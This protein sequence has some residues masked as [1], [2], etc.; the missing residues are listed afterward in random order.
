MSLNQLKTYL[1]EEGRYKY[2]GIKRNCQLGVV[3]IEKTLLTKS[4]FSSSD[5]DTVLQ[6]LDEIAAVIDRVKSEC[7][8]VSSSVINWTITSCLVAIGYGVFKLLSLEQL[9]YEINSL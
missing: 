9:N 4:G 2:D 8:H 7:T 3:S 5:A 6:Q 1:E